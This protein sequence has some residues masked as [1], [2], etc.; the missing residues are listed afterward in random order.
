MPLILNNSFILI[1]LFGASHLILC[2][3]IYHLMTIPSCSRAFKLVYKSLDLCFFCCHSLSKYNLLWFIWFFFFEIW[4]F[5]CF[6][7]CCSRISREGERRK[8]NKHQASFW[9]K[10]LL[11][12]RPWI[13]VDWNRSAFAFLLYHLWTWLVS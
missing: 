11:F 12:R 3:L 9:I 2:L 5:N 10:I 4:Y 13:V 8:R 7:F 6:I 1:F